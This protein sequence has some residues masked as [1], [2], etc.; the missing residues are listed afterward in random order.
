MLIGSH[1]AVVRAYAGERI[2]MRAVTASTGQGCKTA[3]L[4]FG[5][6]QVD[7]IDRLGSVSGDATPVEYDGP[8]AAD[9]RLWLPFR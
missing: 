3:Y 5:L 4:H 1:R 2:H 6:G 9:Q 8:F 7:E